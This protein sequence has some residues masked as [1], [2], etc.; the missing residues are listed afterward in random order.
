[1]SKLNLMQNA[2]KD[3]FDNLHTGKNVVRPVIDFLKQQGYN[4][5]TCWECCDYGNKH[6]FITKDLQQAGFRVFS[7]GLEMLDEKYRFDFLTHFDSNTFYP[8]RFV[9]TNPPYS[10]KDK[11][12]DLAVDLIINKQILGCAF[13]LP[14]DSVAGVARHKSY[15]RALLHDVSIN[16]KVFDKRIDF[17][18]KG[19]CWFNVA[20]FIFYKKGFGSCT[21]DFISK[22]AY[23]IQ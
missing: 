4:N 12:I 9:V 3:K 8:D 20:W 18:G 21:L 16:V 15:K 1:M 7:S 6:S 19:A 23:V 13:L 17:T 10:I 5:I 2:I 22:E 11:F 14:T